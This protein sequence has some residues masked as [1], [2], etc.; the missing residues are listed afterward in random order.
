VVRAHMCLLAHEPSGRMV[1]FFS[2]EGHFGYIAGT[3]QH[4]FGPP[5]GTAGP[6]FLARPR[7]GASAILAATGRVRD[8]HL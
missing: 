1:Y 7:T 4:M 3:D 5:C 2:I 6:R 8:G